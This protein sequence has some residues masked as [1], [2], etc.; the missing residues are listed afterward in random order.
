L[1]SYSWRFNAK[2]AFADPER[3][4]E[5]K[6]YI[7]AERIHK[8]LS[9]IDNMSVSEFEGWFEYFTYK[10]DLEKKEFEKLKR[11]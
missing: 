2:K 3:G 4:L 10:N 1:A 5:L 9:E 6:R 11:K 8:T 7:L